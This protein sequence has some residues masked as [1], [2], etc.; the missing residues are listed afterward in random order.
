MTDKVILKFTKAHGVYVPGDVAGFE[1]VTA[2]RFVAAQ[3]AV[4]FDKAE[5]GTGKVVGDRGASPELT[6]ALADLQAREDAVA[7][8]EAAL[9]AVE[10]EGAAQKSG[11]TDSTVENGAPPKTPVSK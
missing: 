8:R 10:A 3:V 11:K 6:A 1:P 2:E 4:K 9:M 5:H 7:K